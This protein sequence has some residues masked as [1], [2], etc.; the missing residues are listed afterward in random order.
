MGISKGF[1]YRDAVILLTGK[2]SAIA[3]FVDKALGGAVVGSSVFFGPAA[4]ALLG[5]KNELVK[6]GKSQLEGLSGRLAGRKVAER[7]DL[8]E[9]AN[10]VLVVI[11][12]LEACEEE[13]GTLLYQKLEI[14]EQDLKVLATDGADGKNDLPSDWDLLAEPAVACPSVH[15]SIEETVN[16][17]SLRYADWAQ[18][19]LAFIRGLQAWE[20]VPAH[21]RPTLEDKVLELVPHRAAGKYRAYFAKLAGDVPEFS[22][23][24]LSQELEALNASLGADIRTIDE[25]ARSIG[26]SLS[27]VRDLLATVTNS[28]PHASGSRW[29]QSLSDVNA[30]ELRRHLVNSEDEDIEGINSPT[31]EQGYIDPKFR[32]ALYS[33]RASPSSEGWWAA[34]P[35]RTDL[36]GY[37][38][39]HLVSAAATTLPMLIIGDPGAGK[40]T[41]ARVLA[42]RLPASGFL[43]VRVPLRNV[44]ANE[45]I[46]RQIVHGIREAIHEETSWPEFVEAAK[47]LLPV[48]ILDG[49]DELLQATGVS[50][51]DY[52]EKV[53]DF[54]LSE[55]DQ[56]RPVAVIVTS[57]TTVVER[58]RIRTGTPI[59][60]LEQFD[61]EHVESWLGEWAR[62]NARYFDEQHLEPLTWERLNTYRHLASQP[63][64][65]LMLALY[66][67]EDNALRSAPGFGRSVLYERLLKKFIRREV[68]KN[69]SALDSI[70][71]E[72][73]L[74]N[75][76]N[77]LSLVA[78]GM[79]NR[80]KQFIS[81]SD[82]NADLVALG[83]ASGI[84]PAHQG[85]F[86]QT[87]SPG[88]LLLGKFFFIHKA[89]ALEHNQDGEEGRA[90]R[91]GR[92]FEFMHATFGEYLVARLAGILTSTLVPP[93]RNQSFLTNNRGSDPALFTALFS[94]QAFSASTQIV[95][96]LRE[97]FEQKSHSISTYDVV[98]WML[99]DLWKEDPKT[100]YPNYQP[101]TLPA[102][103]K[104]ATLSANL[105]LL[106]AA[107]NSEVDITRLFGGLSTEAH[108]MWRKWSLLWESQLDEGAYSGLIQLLR[109]RKREV[110][111]TDHIVYELAP[112]SSQ[113]STSHAALQGFEFTE[114]HLERDLQSIGTHGPWHEHLAQRSSLSLDWEGLRSAEI[115]R[116]FENRLGRF[117][118]R[119]YFRVGDSDGSNHFTPGQF[120]EGNFGG[121]FMA[122][123]AFTTSS[124]PAFRNRVMS[125]L[126]MIKA[127][128]SEPELELPPALVMLKLLAAKVDWLSVADW[129]KIFD[130]LDLHS[131]DA[132]LLTEFHILQLE[133]I[134]E[135]WALEGTRVMQ[136]SPLFH[137]ARTA[138][139]HLDPAHMV[140]AEPTLAA[141]LLLAMMNADA[142]VR[143]IASEFA[144]FE[145]WIDRIGLGNLSN[146][147]PRLGY[148]VL[149]AMKYHHC[150]T[151]SRYQAPNVLD[152]VSDQT[153]MRL[154]SSQVAYFAS[155]AMAPTPV[156][157]RRTLKFVGR[158]VRVGGS[159]D[160]FEEELSMQDASRSPFR[161]LRPKRQRTQ[162][163]Q[164]HSGSGSL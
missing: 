22:F 140:D 146:E 57:R 116:F 124:G 132:Q 29:L 50:H 84:Q 64:L 4:L 141:R 95:P 43:P 121:L 164:Q 2:D 130:E 153:L 19:F 159:I 68:L 66:D 82:V 108:D 32:T 120:D 89:E 20:S 46:D 88:E 24:A 160:S 16:Q 67:A 11:S 131:D 36:G 23:W 163:M 76:L 126:Q 39:G 102:Q 157:A 37:L 152:L 106:L 100:R 118:S 70:A 78:L 52:L 59:V 148:Q 34:A 114:S 151:W 80:A 105:M 71:L 128:P 49:F 27:S 86:L 101:V 133:I 79:F 15:Q 98:R 149:S 134:T 144:S 48:I 96:F 75:H 38:T 104:I 158:W 139:A 85:R 54:Q 91:L 156:A 21:E 77:E 94:M 147:D 60:K 62:A 44:A 3:D 112:S 92:T 155:A 55:A 87:L 150:L 13:L 143:L 161:N 1:T 7:T 18:R 107:D 93:D 30:A 69:S 136:E 103:A 45:S 12:F 162:A 14:T 47:Q 17:L 142:P 154:S 145:D 9:A 58:A 97:F 8:R 25:S 122:S 115:I 53:A 63:V 74:E 35:T 135:L 28:L 129:I 81:E 72:N 42:A 117:G 109:L 65:L 26:S 40:S 113:Q 61:Q 138:W 125:V 90:L 41:L 10:A 6:L 51:S 119:L 56:G 5:P 111:S 99:T 123:L 31:V 110:D 73:E 127:W 137:A 83:Y 33:R